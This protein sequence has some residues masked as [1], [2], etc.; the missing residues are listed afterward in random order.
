MA[1]DK[2]A[3]VSLFGEDPVEVDPYD[4]TF[5]ELDEAAR[6]LALLPNW[7][8]TRA[9]MAAQAFVIYKRDAVYGAWDDDKYRG[10]RPKD[11]AYPE[12]VEANAGEA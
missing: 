1:D 8:T 12:P 3:L 5:A 7:Q 10:C 11:L 9:M 2:P 4:M 6:L